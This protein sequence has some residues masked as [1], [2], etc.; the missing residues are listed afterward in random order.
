MKKKSLILIFCLFVFSMSSKENIDLFNECNNI[1]SFDSCYCT[2]QYTDRATNQRLK[3][4]VGKTDYRLLS[5]P[6]KK[7]YRKVQ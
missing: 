1:N 2:E 3:R 6:I 4:C 5:E 7:H